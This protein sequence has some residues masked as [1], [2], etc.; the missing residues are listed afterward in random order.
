M[1]NIFVQHFI[2]SFLCT[3]ITATICAYLQN[4]LSIDRVGILVFF[5]IGVAGLIFS[6]T[7]AL[8]QKWLKQS[9]KSTVIVVLSLSIYLMVYTYLFHVVDV[10]WHAVSEGLVQLTLFQ[11]TLHSERSIWLAFLFTFCASWLYQKT[12][13]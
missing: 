7:F 4:T 2:Y 8:F 6:L 11:K 9:V 12:L 1:K 10:D 5:V 13:K 3:L